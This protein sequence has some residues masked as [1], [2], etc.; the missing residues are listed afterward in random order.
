VSGVVDGDVVAEGRHVEL[1]ALSASHYPLLHAEL[2][3]PGVVETWRSRGRYIPIGEFD[4]F[5]GNGLYH[6]VLARRTDD[7]GLVGYLEAR[8]FEPVDLHCYVSVAATVDFRGTGLIVEATALF[9]DVL[10]A[11]FPPRKAYLLLSDDA[12]ATLRSGLGTLL[13]E[14][15]VLRGHVV[16]N[17]RVQDV[18]VASITR[19]DLPRR[20]ACHPLARQARWRLLDVGSGSFPSPADGLARLAALAGC[21]V[22]ELDRELRVADLG[23]D[24]LDV[25]ELRLAMEEAAGRVLPD[26]LVAEVRTVGD[27]VGWLDALV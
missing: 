12:R 9:L 21:P 8:D 5:L 17:G 2:L 13:D 6:G 15:A 3:R 7:H 18:T 19:E 27:V 23:L 14:E 24:S 22:E 1:V 25:L 10:F 16:L 20:L 11:G 26:A 4:R